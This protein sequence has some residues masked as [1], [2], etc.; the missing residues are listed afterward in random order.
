MMGVDIQVRHS[1]FS[2]PI[3]NFV[4]AN[5]HSQILITAANAAVLVLRHLN[6]H[7]CACTHKPIHFLGYCQGPQVIWETHNIASQACHT[8]LTVILSPSPTH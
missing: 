7:A 3:H 6:G 2:G 1:Q 5:G 8:Q 4:C